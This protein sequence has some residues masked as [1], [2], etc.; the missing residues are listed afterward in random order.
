VVNLRSRI[1]PHLP[2]TS[3]GCRCFS[4]SRGGRRSCR[5]CSFGRLSYRGSGRS[6]FGR[7]A[8]RIPFP[9]APVTRARTFFRS[10]FRIGTVLTD[11]GSA[12]RDL[13]GSSRCESDEEEDH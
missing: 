7:S 5:R 8:I 11:T 1:H 9:D 6:L 10:G 13:S 2:G 3:A 4:G 12:C